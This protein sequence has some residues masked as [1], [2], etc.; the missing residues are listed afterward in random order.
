[1]R[2]DINKCRICGNQDLQ[3][4]FDLGHQYLTGRFPSNVDE[5]LP[6]GPVELV[7]CSGINSCGLVQLKQSYDL[8]EMYG[9]NYGYKSSL[10]PSMV[11]HLHGKVDK[12]M[13]SSFLTNGDLI[14]D[15]GSNDATTLNRFP[16]GEFILLGVDPSAGKF[17]NCYRSDVSLIKDF[18]SRKVIVDK[19]GPTLKAKL[20]S[21]YSMFYDLEDPLNFMREIEDSLD[22]DGI[23]IF[24][25]S[26]L[27]KMIDTNSF[28]TICHEHLEFY[29][30]KQIVWMAEKANLKIVDVEFNDV[31]GGSFIV[32]AAKFNSNIQVQA[33][34]IVSILEEEVAKGYDSV[35]LWESFTNRVNQ[36]KKNF[37]SFLIEAKKNGSRVCGIGGS[38]KGN[39]L[40]QY[41][42][43]GP[44]LIECIGE[45]N[46]DK[47]GCFTPGSKIPM[48]PEK[49]VLESNPDYLVIF[50]WH[51]KKFFLS[52]EKFKNR[53]LVFPLPN[54]EIIIT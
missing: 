29:T 12:I 5:V 17:E 3:K 43:I 20:I 22:N 50:P 27:P 40:L 36:N 44:D 4:V 41:Y 45:V 28:D 15:I 48:L 35:H 42:G 52:S 9:D 38:T 8:S 33:S 16:V 1:M 46:K 19:I 39:V 7:K 47:F 25:Q 34:K 53:K 32:T 21:S 2:I 18:F 37:L 6:S 23:W 11:A 31:N 26:Y 51:F 54:F 30:L 49:E 14:I 13:S 24:E 10:N